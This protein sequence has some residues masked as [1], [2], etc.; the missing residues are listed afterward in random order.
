MAKGRHSVSERLDAFSMLWELDGDVLHCRDCDATVSAHDSSVRHV[1]G[2]V[3][4]K[5]MRNPWYELIL[6]MTQL[7][8]ERKERKQ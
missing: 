2:C 7:Y 3:L 8:R 4:D 1:D 6:I 5:A